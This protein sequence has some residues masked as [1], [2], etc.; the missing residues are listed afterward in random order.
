MIDHDLLELRKNIN[1]FQNNVT[2][3]FKKLINYN[4]SYFKIFQN[5]KQIL[6]L[7]RNYNLKKNP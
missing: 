6:N 7:K 2:F 1:S 4:S 5:K 3:K